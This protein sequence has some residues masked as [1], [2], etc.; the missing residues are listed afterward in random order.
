MTKKK[1]TGASP[2]EIYI[3]SLNFEFPLETFSRQHSSVPL[4]ST[5]QNFAIRRQVD[6]Q[7]SHAHA[8]QEHS[9]EYQIFLN[10]D[11]R[12]SFHPASSFTQQYPYE[13]HVRV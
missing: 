9:R 2:F 12:T 1:E 8:K 13:Q 4:P 10:D 7:V 3:I 6:G 5:N 11:H